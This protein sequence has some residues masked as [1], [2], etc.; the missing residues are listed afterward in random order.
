TLKL[1]PVTTTSMVTRYHL[2]TDTPEASVLVV[3]VV[4]AEAANGGLGAVGVPVTVAR[5]RRSE[6]PFSM[7]NSASPLAAAG[8][9]W[10]YS[11]SRP[12]PLALLCFAMRPSALR[13]TLP[14][15]M[16]G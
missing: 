13:L 8:G 10:L 12:A 2:L 3:N 14:V 1:A 7:R 6:L 11:A 15:K 5:T 4:G 16:V 9:G